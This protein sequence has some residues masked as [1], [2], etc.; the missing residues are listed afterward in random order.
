[1]FRRYHQDYQVNAIE[2]PAVAND[3]WIEVII[4][5]AK[6]YNCLLTFGSDSHGYP[7]DADH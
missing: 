7:A 1:M 4:S 5:L 2:I 6:E 3:R